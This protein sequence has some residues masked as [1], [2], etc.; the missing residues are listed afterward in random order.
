MLG[1]MEEDKKQYQKKDLYK[2]HTMAKEKIGI[3]TLKEVV[4]WNLLVL[5]KIFKLIEKAQKGKR[6]NG[7]DAIGFLQPL[8]KL[9]SLVGK[10]QLIGKEWVDLDDEEKA[11]LC[12]MVKEG[13]DIENDKAEE[14]AERIFFILMEIGD[15]ITDLVK[16]VK[17]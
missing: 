5:D 2:I 11:Y 12:T 10:H 13:F 8:I 6:V 15:C 17:G 1:S 3:E 4:E 16:L 9:I 14:V 7:W